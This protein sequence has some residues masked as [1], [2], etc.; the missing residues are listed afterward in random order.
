[1]S[2]GRGSTKLG[3]IGLSL[4]R[5]RDERVP[6]VGF[7]L[8]VMVTAFAFAL[9][10]R[11]LEQ[12]S[13]GALRT[14]LAAAP[15]AER[16]LRVIEVARGTALPLEQLSD[17][18][19]TAE[20]LQASFPPSIRELIV[21]RG[22]V[23]ET[24]SW[25]AISGTGTASLMTL[26]MQDGVMDRL[27]LVDGRAATE[28]T[29]VVADPRPDALPSQRAVVY[30]AVMSAAAAERM[31]ISTGSTVVLAPSPYDPAMVGLNLAA[32][33]TI[34]GKYEVIDPDDPY[35]MEDT[36]LAGF[37]FNPVTPFV[38]YLDTTIL[39]PTGAYVVF[40]A[41][42]RGEGVPLRYQWRYY[43]DPTALDA[44]R[45]EEAIGEL[46]RMESNPPRTGISA[47]LSDTTLR[48]GLLR[49]LL[50]HQQTWRSA[51]AVL[52]VVALGAAVIAVATL[53]VVAVLA[54]AGRRRVAALLRA[55]GASAAQVLGSMAVEGLLLAVPAALIGLALAVALTPSA[56]LLRAA[57]PATIVAAVATII[58]LAV[59]APARSAAATEPGR[60]V[61]FVQRTTPRRLVIEAVV[62]LVAIGAALL[63]RERGI[64]GASAAGSGADAAAGADP[65]I[66]IVPA[67]AGVAAGIIAM[68][69][70][71][72][73]AAALGALAAHRRD[74]VPVLATRRVIR[75]GGAT[76][77]LL[78]LVATAT[79]GAFASAALAHMERAADLVAWQQVGAHY[80]VDAGARSLPAEL[81]PGRLPGVERHAMG[82]LD[83]YATG[84]GTGWLLTIDSAAYLEV[85]RGT[86]GDP[87]LPPELL[88]AVAAEPLPA[89]VSADYGVAPGGI[90]ERRSGQRPVSMRAVSV[91]TTFPGIPAGDS[92][93]VVS[94]AHLEAIDPRT[95]PRPSVAY[96][97]VAEAAEAELRPAAESVASYL[98]VASQ[99][100]LAARQRSSPA[101]GAVSA[102]VAAAAVAAVAYAA[103]AVT[104]ALA[105]AGAARRAETAHL[106]VFGLSRRQQT[107]LVFVEF[108][109]SALIAYAIGVALGL[110]LFAFLQP[111]LG[112]GTIIG[113]PIDVPVMV[114]PVHLAVLLAAVGA[115]VLIGWSLGILSQRD[116]DPA[117][118]VRGGIE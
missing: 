118:A 23:V 21:D 28:V 37:R 75:G 71:P 17:V 35:W 91:R 53:A 47:V 9:G 70:Y 8:L 69:I 97:R 36:A 82:S 86:A 3:V 41:N 113:S 74:L 109:P 33:V 18:E 1:M 93:V 115:I 46:R 49:V 30:E 12:V 73:P 106:R 7:V 2:A 66:A 72:L 10:P 83:V 40:Q 54:S 6:V 19:E 67:M 4:R 34:V 55:R 104:A 59:V 58:L 100:E 103:L 13:N 65:L 112:L 24:P 16:N 105:L 22:L 99:F 68:R 60:A 62:V 94:R 81:D 32:E 78:I 102:G 31:G 117:S 38:D 14:E 27:R 107:W 108:G 51:E 39:L 84:R 80:R 79:I 77:V 50:A 96:L 98:T 5:L 87:G 45:L 85:V 20:A 116:I 61:R 88:G 110:T 11:L 25:E 56:T 42:T 95:L 48:S 29:R 92:F 43:V 76:P 114:E 64:S 63:V 89:I 101:I 26:R 57:L 52:A 15:S 111:G 90:F 44:D